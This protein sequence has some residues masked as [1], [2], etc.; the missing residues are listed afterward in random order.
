MKYFLIVAFVVGLVSGIQSQTEGEKMKWEVTMH[1]IFGELRQS[2]RTLSATRLES[3]GH[4]QTF[5]G[6]GVGLRY[7]FQGEL[8][9][10]LLVNIQYSKL[11]DQLIGTEEFLHKAGFGIGTKYGFL[12]KKFTV[13][14]G[15]FFGQLPFFENINRKPDD[16]VERYIGYYYIFPDIKC[17]FQEKWFQAYVS[18]TSEDYA[19]YGVRSDIG[20][21]FLIGKQ[22]YHGLGFGIF[23]NSDN[24]IFLTGRVSAFKNRFYFEPKVS[25]GSNRFE[26]FNLKAGVRF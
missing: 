13:E 3:H 10:F 19:V 16:M 8:K 25:F 23:Q 22:K 14:L 5:K 15:V 18:M 21:N 11:T 7:N 9:P 6:T 17:I 26:H 1:T 4:T 12:Y 20:L 2:T 24:G